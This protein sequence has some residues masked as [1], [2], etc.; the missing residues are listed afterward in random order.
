M[1]VPG[2]TLLNQLPGTGGPVFNSL[3]AVVMAKGWRS[4]RKAAAES[5]LTLEYSLTV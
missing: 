3:G 2:I 1:A 5:M 4:R